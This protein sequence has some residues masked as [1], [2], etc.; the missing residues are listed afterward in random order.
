MKLC[1]NGLHDTDQTGV[2][3]K[4]GARHCLLCI[5]ANWRKYTNVTGR[6]VRKSYDKG[7][8][9]TGRR[10]K[11]RRHYLKSRDSSTA[12]RRRLYAENPEPHRERSRRQNVK[13]RAAGGAYNYFWQCQAR[14]SL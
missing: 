5:R 3:T 1:R 4:R 11:S 7:K 2:Y 6:E 12:R 8:G 9:L 13:I 14:N 10:A